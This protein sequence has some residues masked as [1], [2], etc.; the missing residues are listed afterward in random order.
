MGI[1]VDDPERVRTDDPQTVAAGVL[2]QALLEQSALRPRL[3]ETGGHD[4]GP[5]H[6]RRAAGGDGVEHLFRRHRDD[7]QIDR[8]GG[9][10]QRRETGDA[11]DHLRFRVDPHDRTG[12]PGMPQIAQQQ[13][14]DRALPS[15][16]TDHG[17]RS[18]GQQ[19]GDRPRLTPMLPRLHDVPGGL[20]GADVEVQFDDTLVHRLGRFVAGLFERGEHPPVGR[21]DLCDEPRDPP[22]PSRSGE[23]FQQ[24]GP[25]ASALMVVTDHECDLRLRPIDPV[26]ATHPD[27]LPG[28]QRDQRDPVHVVNIREPNE[29][30]LRQSGVRSEE[31][32]VDRLRGEGVVEDRQ[33]IVVV[34]PDRPD[35]ADPAIAENDIG[36]PVLGVLF[37]HRLRGHGSTVSIARSRTRRPARRAGCGLLPRR[38]HLRVYNFL[39]LLSKPLITKVSTADTPVVGHLNRPRTTL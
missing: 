9:A 18:R 13:I 25:Q 12:E 36:F 27:D 37:R 5:E 28:H 33:R 20:G 6:P 17:H 19:R 7:G 35:V 1:G 11:G 34:G 16:R 15:A 38:G 30:L 24:D 31:P 2:H 26:V 8:T 39:Q 23:V 10:G 3:G 21:Q 14:A 4:D 29:V 32:V 22:L